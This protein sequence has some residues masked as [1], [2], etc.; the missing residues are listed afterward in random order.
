MVARKIALKNVRVFDG[1]RLHEPGTVVLDG[2][3]IGVDVAGAEGLDAQGGVLLPGLIDAHV[4]LHGLESLEQLTGFGV[5]TAL[6]MSN[7]PPA[8]VDALRG[9]AGLTDI[10]SAGTL[11]LRRAAVTAACPAGHRTRW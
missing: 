9:R 4:H 2:D 3:R 6:D 7:W 11:P 8:D 5:T 10:R 1:W